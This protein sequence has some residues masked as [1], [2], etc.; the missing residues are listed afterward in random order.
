MLKAQAKVHWF[1]AF[2]QSVSVE[3]KRLPRAA[4]SLSF[5]HEAQ[6]DASDG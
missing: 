2:G 5:K 6:P 4:E 3:V 1:K